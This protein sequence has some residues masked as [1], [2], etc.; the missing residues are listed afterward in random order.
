[1]KKSIIWFAAAALVITGCAKV[2]ST[3]LNEANKRHFEA[4]VSANCPQAARTPLG[5]YVIE[6]QDGSGD[7]IL[8][9][10]YMMAT[11]VIRS[12]DGTVTSSSTEEM[13]KQ[14]GT[15]SESSFYGP[16]VWYVGDNNLSAGL[17]DA[18]AG[19]HVGLKI[20]TAIPGWLITTDRYD[21]VQEYLDNVSGTDGIYEM[22][23]TECFDDVVKWEVD[24]LVRHLRRVFPKVDPTD[25][26]SLQPDVL[27]NKKYGFYYVQDRPSTHPDSTFSSDAEVYIKYVG[28]LLNG[29]VFDTN[30]KDTAKFYGIYSASRAYA[31]S[32]IN[33]GETY[34]DLTMTSGK[35]SIIDGFAFAIFQMKPYEKGTALFY[36]G[37]GYGSN[38]SGDN[39]PS[40]SPLRFDIE[41]VDKEQ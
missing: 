17:E 8:D 2:K 24:S 3:G 21:T 41:L 16:A 40:Y 26:V 28:R 34:A 18:L 1:M 27:F 6:A 33:W 29:K 31:P 11:H 39:I 30:I 36:S 25:T 14:L 32:L 19:K 13:A 38:G 4:W 7:K 5:S 9:H 12:L 10:E 20:K 23:V 35:S 22:E 15:Y 37:Y